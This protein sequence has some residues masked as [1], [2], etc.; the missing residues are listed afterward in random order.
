MR[1]RECVCEREMMMPVC[2]STS[3]K[4]I[5]NLESLEGGNAIQNVLKQ[6]QLTCPTV[7]LAPI[8]ALGP[9]SEILLSKP[10][11]QTPSPPQQ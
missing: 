5:Y 3:A 11:K 7:E 2:L 8:C 1:D 4:P 9:A 6:Q 10:E